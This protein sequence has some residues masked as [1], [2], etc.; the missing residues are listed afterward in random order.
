MLAYAQ[1]VLKRPYRSLCSAKLGS[2]KQTERYTFSLGGKGF[3]Q[4]L[5]DGS[6]RGVPCL[7][8]GEGRR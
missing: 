7:R 6:H 3:P 2:D 5:L 8:F 4:T 1:Y